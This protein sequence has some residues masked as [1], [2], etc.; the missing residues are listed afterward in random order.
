MKKT[1][2]KK[3]LTKTEQITYIQFKPGIM[4]PQFDL[5]YKT[6]AVKIVREMR[7]YYN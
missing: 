1:N 5:G 2:K 7:G 6:D 4:A 3:K